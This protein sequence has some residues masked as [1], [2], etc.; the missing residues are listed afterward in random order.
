MNGMLLARFDL[1]RKTV[2][3]LPTTLTEDHAFVG[4]IEDAA[5]FISPK[6][7]LAFSAIR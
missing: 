2:E 3:F 5:T 6:G 4:I 1:I 7:G